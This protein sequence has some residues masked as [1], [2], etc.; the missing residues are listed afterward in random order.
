MSGE[1]T[2]LAAAERSE[3]VERCRPTVLRPAGAFPGFRTEA[4]V[5]RRHRLRDVVLDAEHMVLLRN[6]LKL[7][8]TNYLRPPDAYAALA[9]FP[10]RV[11]EVPDEGGPVC[12]CTDATPG[13]YYHWMRHTLPAIAAFLRAVPANAPARLALPALRP[14]QED[15]LRL[16]GAADVER[17]RIEPGRQ[18]RLPVA[19][20]F[21]VTPGR[22]DFARSLTTRACF[23][24]MVSALP[25]ANATGGAI[26][27]SRSDAT[28][29]VM[30]GE[31][32][33]TA[34]LEELGVRIVVPGQL[35]L[36][37]Q[38]RTFRDASL[39]IGPHGA[40]MT[41]ILACR[42]GTRI[43]ELV[44]AHYRN[45]CFAALS[46][47]GGLR[48]LSDAFASD[49]EG[50]DFMREWSVDVDHVVRR[51]AAL[52]RPRWRRAMDRLR[53]RSDAA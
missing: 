19:E 49:G 21:D 29:R 18:Y 36:A 4:A 22:A 25:P 50:P 48:H 23:R 12:V 34:Q 38:L 1:T 46:L 10:D 16:I 41:N 47:Q 43:Y 30:R 13:N 5:L 53:R 2:L 42:P 26:Y 33:L 14:W 37:E 40:G 17:V 6:G 45:P 24:R 9:V 15:S 32:R 31:A 27:V 20:Y 28:Q 52:R 44:P 39:V 8:D 3:V 35:T 51:V 11:T 7:S